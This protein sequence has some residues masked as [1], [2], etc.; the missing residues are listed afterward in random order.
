[1]NTQ[2]QLTTKSL[3]LNKITYYNLNLD[4]PI[5]FKTYTNNH[6]LNNF[7]LID[8]QSNTTINTNTL[9]FALRHTTNIH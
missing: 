2:T 9:D 5:P 3:K 1:M 4:Q 6:T 7:I 8:H